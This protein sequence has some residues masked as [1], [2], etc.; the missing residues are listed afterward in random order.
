MSEATRID[1]LERQVERLRNEFRSYAA[2][3]QRIFED[4]EELFLEMAKALDVMSASLENLTPPE[5]RAGQCEET[6][7]MGRAFE[8]QAL[9]GIFRNNL[10]DLRARITAMA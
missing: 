4:V 2:G 1:E 10:Q 8:M 6:G 9:V 5:E 7:V 3:R